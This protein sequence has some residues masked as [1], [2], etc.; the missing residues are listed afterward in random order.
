[1]SEGD[2]ESCR[3]GVDPELDQLRSRLAALEREYRSAFDQ[4]QREADA[5]F[6]Q[7]QLSQLIA[8]GGSPSELG[9]AAVI[10]LTRLAGAMEGALW[11]G[12]P[13][14]P[15]LR[16]IASTGQAT[17]PIRQAALPPHPPSG[18]H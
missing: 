11:L 12:V 6:A 18:S 1:M 9:T 2:G 17:L 14:G 15:E 7:Y 10:E 13:E 5:L 4:A 3:P 8:S 16:L